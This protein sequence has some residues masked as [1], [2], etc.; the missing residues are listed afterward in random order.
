MTLIK[1]SSIKKLTLSIFATLYL[2]FFIFTILN[3]YSYSK[4]ESLKTEKL[5]KNFNLSLSKQISEKINSISDVSKYPLLIPEISNLHNILRSDNVLDINNY[6]YLKHLCEMILI[7]NDSINGAYIYDL[8]GRGT[9][10]SRNTSTDILINP[11][12]EWWFLK[13]IQSDNSTSIF[14]N[15]NIKSIV[16]VNTSSNENLIAL[17]R[18]IIDISS[19]EIT[20]LLL[21]TIPTDKILNLLNNDIAFNN[22]ILSL[23]DSDGQ[24]IAETNKNPLF[25]DLY[26][27]TQLITT[28]TEP[29]IEYMYKDT[30]YIVTYNYIQFCDW[31]LINTIKKSDAFNLNTLYMMFFFINLI[32]FLIMSAILY[33]FLKN[34]I[35][36]PI[37]SLAKNMKSSNLEKNLDTEIIYDKDDEI[38]FLVNSYNKMKNRINYLININYKNALEH[39]ELELQQLQNQINP[40]FIYNTLESIHM[41]A[42]INDDI[43][44]STMAEYFGEIIRYSMNRRINTVTLKEEL[45]II[46]NY[47]YLQKIRFDQLFT[48]ENMVSDELLSCEIIKMIIQPLI[49]NAIY[50]GL[51]EC[52]GNGKIIIQGSKVN[53]NLLLT[54]S[55]NG[56]GIPEEKLQDLNDYINDKN[57]NFNGI[58]LRNINKRLK[59]N[60]G[61]NYGLEIFSI[62]GNGTSMV[63]TLPFI[64]K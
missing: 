40:H 15:I 11:S 35:F 9:F 57:H 47:I 33:L 2:I 26:Q 39:K 62:E 52:S 18:Q 32:F 7:Q 21:I 34:R 13:S 25:N 31:I 56:I 49:E 41:M 54:I 22:Q 58:A 48:I 38:G 28:N 8:K 63:L 1:N 46:D 5:I 37:E 45:K 24:L 12:L 20:G 44:T 29:Q 27:N 64:I 3:L 17:T 60:Y 53:N 4:Y 42:E 16:D 30:S 19:N 61:E 6:N 59:L 43:E 50:H 10:A 23:Y 36:N 14:S 51:S 55:D